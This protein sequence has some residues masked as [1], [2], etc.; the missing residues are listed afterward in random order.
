MDQT[1]VHWIAHRWLKQ[2]K[3]RNKMVQFDAILVLMKITLQIG[4]P[5]NAV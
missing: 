1:Q 3:L 4:V 2:K 5:K